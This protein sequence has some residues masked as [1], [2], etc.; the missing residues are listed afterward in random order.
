VKST[1]FPN[2]SKSFLLY[3][4]WASTVADMSDEEAGQAIKA[5]FQFQLTGTLPELPR[6]VKMG[7]N[8]VLAQME[9]DHFKYL[10]VCA[11]RS[12]AGSKGAKQKLAN[13]GK[14]KQTKQ[15]LA[16]QAD[17]DT[18]I[19][20]DIDIETESYSCAEPPC[21]STPEETVLTFDCTGNPKQWHLTKPM[22]EEFK[23]TFDTIDV[24]DQSRR[25]WQWLRVNPTKRKTAGGMPKFLNSWFNRAVD[26]NWKNTSIKQPEIMR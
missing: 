16:N 25:A 26:N 19:E 20:R 5:L 18:D 2:G 1:K 21:N 10:D 9:R 13:A 4:D 14:R 7:I 8:Q 17:I 23:V 3:K 24:E 22:V 6:I 12:E 15:K 11:K